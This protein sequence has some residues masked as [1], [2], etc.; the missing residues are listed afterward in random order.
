MGQDIETLEGRMRP[1]SD[2]EAGFW[3][4]KSLSREVLA[5]DN[6]FVF[7]QGL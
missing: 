2:S 5:A 3:G 6:D 4:P 7:S 1:G